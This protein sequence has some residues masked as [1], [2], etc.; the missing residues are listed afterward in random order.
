[1]GTGDTQADLDSGF[2]L[3]WV[4]ELAAEVRDQR[5]YLTQLDEAV[6]T[7][8]VFSVGGAAGPLYG[9][10]FRGLGKALGD[11]QRFDPGDLL[12]ALRAGL[13][14][15]QGLGA[16]A[17]GDKTI[18][19]A[20][21]PALDAFE[22]ALRADRDLATVTALTREAAEEGMRSTT[23]MQARKG[24]ASYL[25]PRSVGHQ[26]PGATSTALLFSAL[27]LAAGGRDGAMR[28]RP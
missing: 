28:G 16:A 4:R 21:A 19:D 2:V 8:L 26:D 6:G 9:T 18:V 14:A 17:E 25:G 12:V 27:A 15:I 23:P 7:A 22:G 24:R 11:R 10:G 3:D 13:E 5:D 1:M 20:F